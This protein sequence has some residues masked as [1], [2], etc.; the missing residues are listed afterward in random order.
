LGAERDEE[1][2]LALTELRDDIDSLKRHHDSERPDEGVDM[3]VDDEL[4]QQGATQLREQLEEEELDEEMDV[5]EAAAGAAGA[6]EDIGEK[7]TKHQP[8]HIEE[9]EMAHTTSTL[10]FRP[11]WSQTIDQAKAHFRPPGPSS[12][13]TEGR[14]VGEDESTPK[15][16]SVDNTP[17]PPFFTPWSQSSDGARAPLRTL[18]ARPSF[19][20]TVEERQAKEEK[21]NSA[22]WRGPKPSQ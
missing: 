16:E 11:T 2:E 17:M 13:R 18:R 20:R 14:M 8:E 3:Q 4:I 6:E 7:K 22:S 10:P 19:M 5:D 1:A 15:K 21:M 9:E 12:S